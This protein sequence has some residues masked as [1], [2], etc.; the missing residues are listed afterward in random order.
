MTYG[1]Y[2]ESDVILTTM[3]ECGRCDVPIEARARFVVAEN[4]I[5]ECRN[6]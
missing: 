1:S 4:K 5:R 3:L 6:G 2:D